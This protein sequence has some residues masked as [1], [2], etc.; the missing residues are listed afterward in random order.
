[1][2]NQNELNEFTLEEFRQICRLASSNCRRYFSKLA[3][4]S[5]INES[6]SEI[7]WNKFK[8]NFI[9]DFL[10]IIYVEEH[11][12]WRREELRARGGIS[13]NGRKV[14]S[15]ATALESSQNWVGVM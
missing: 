11:N 1:M 12:Q 2:K 7:S 10:Q 8:K 5:W 4:L 6:S 9:E 13:K 3:D 15:K 14:W